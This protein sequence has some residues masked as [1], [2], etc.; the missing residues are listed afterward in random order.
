MKIVI[1]T[2][3]YYPM[4]NGVA[5]FSKNL[6][7]GLKKRGH[8][9]MVL[10][11][12]IS[13]KFSVEKDPD[14]NFTVVRLKST[15]MYLYPDQIEKIPNDKKVLGIKMPQLLYKN[16]LHVSYNPYSDIRRVLED[17]KPDIIHNQT[18]GPLAL[19]IFRY[20]KKRNIP[21]VMTDHTYPDNLTQ[22]VK[23]PKFAKK[24]INAA[25]N[26]YFM[27]FLRRSEYATLPTRQAITDLLPKNHHSF[28]VPVEAL[29]NGI[30]LS[31]FTKGPASEEIYKKYAIPKNVP[32]ILYVGR[33]DPEKSLDIL[34]NSFK[35]LIK[36]AP[37][38]HLV[39]VGDGTAREK[40]EKMIKRKKLGSQTHFIGRVIGDDLSQIYRTGTVF[41]ITSKTETQSIVLME[42]MASG[43]PAIAVNAGAVTELVKDGENG[44]IFEPDDT[45]GIAS[46]I[47]TIISN[48]ELR[49]KMSKNALKMIT[50]HDI[51]YTLSRFEKI[52][53]N[54]LQSHSK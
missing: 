53:N 27:S 28:K 40:L 44:F 51:N 32:I 19:A 52:Y 21:I 20:A 18:S 35:K 38:A 10:A 7:T 12:S 26:A 24:P 9:V 43:L 46:G 31:H 25:M 39:M 4:I 41:V 11:P 37:K 1:S 16:G 34:V 8:Q 15:R 36:E 47:N 22:Q 17:F 49:E 14:Y 30:D 42:A 3:V 29:S 2:D 23:L 33:I 48:K 50:K 6:A 54:V 13:G 45:A 5:V